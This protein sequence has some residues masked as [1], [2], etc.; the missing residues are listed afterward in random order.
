MAVLVARL[1]GRAAM[2]AVDRFL[3]LAVTGGDPKG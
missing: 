2:S 1:V 3:K